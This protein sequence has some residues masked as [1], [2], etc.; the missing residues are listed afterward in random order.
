M[1]VL[2]HLEELR[3]RV[4]KAGVALLVTTSISFIFTVQL[5]DFLTAPIGGRAAL[6]SIEVTENISVFVRVALLAGVALGLPFVLY[7]A[8]AYIAPGLTRRE[9][10]WLY[11]FIPAATVFFLG[12]VAFAWFVMVPIAVPFLIDFL[13]IPTQPRPLNYIGFISSLLFWVGIS[14]E[15]PLVVFLLAKLKWVTA[16]HLIRGWRYAFMGIAT[17]AAVVTPTADPVNMGLAMLP[18]LTLY[19]ISIVLARIA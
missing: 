14:F 3:A 10:H 7:Q 15:M 9:R 4:L 6:A 12:G 2:E 18:L 17:A 13:G 8:I 16:G 1:T 5:I 11:L 19:L